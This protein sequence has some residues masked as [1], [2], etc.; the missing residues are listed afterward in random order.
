V[1]QRGATFMLRFKQNKAHDDEHHGLLF[2][3]RET[4]KIGQENCLD[5]F[6]ARCYLQVTMLHLNPPESF[7]CGSLFVASH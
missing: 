6:S 5:K 4:E 2:L 1:I 7:R 3:K